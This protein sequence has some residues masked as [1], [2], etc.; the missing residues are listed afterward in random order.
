MPASIDLSVVVPFF[1]EEEN[2][3]A[4][5]DEL[6]GVLEQF[7]RSYEMVFVDDGS[8]DKTFSVL[9]DVAKKDDAVVVVR[10]RRNFGQT[11]A[12]AAG[13][14][15]AKGLVIVPMD[16]DLQNDPA[17]IPK[18]LA[19][20]AEG[21]ECVS[22]W[23]K[24]RQDA[25]IRVLPS[26]VANRLIG[27]LSGVRI[28]DYG[29]TLKAYRRDVIEGVRLYGEMHRFIP[30]YAH[31]QGARVTEMVVNHRARRA[32]VSKYGFGRI[33]R[34]VL[35][36][37]VV[38]FLFQ[39]LTKPIYVFGGFGLVALILSFLALCAAVGLKLAGLKDLVSTPLPLFSGISGLIGIQAVLTGLLAEVLIRTYYESQGKRP[40]LVGSVI[41][42]GETKI[43]ERRE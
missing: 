11:A 25:G 9:E 14:E 31:W 40:Y 15:R 42:K 20:M 16:G 27:W 36:L 12:L 7:G 3:R 29:C 19:K 4:L 2:A 33:P 10:F 41:E 1:N 17:E 35:D 22:G 24:N 38:K 37:I 39:Y 32:G 26:K 23:R 8:T 30:I 21:Y 28:H 18:L 34:V 5:Y 6:K 43:P 13:I